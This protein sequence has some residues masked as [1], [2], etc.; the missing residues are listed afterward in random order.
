MCINIIYYI[1][2]HAPSCAL[3]AL[4]IKYTCFVLYNSVLCI[5][6]NQYTYVRAKSLLIFG[7]NMLVT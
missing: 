7:L 6:T 5:C 3:S 2:S 4:T 1:S